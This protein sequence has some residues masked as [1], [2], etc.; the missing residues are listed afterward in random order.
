MLHYNK[1]DILPFDVTR[2]VKIDFHKCLFF[3]MEAIKRP[4]RIII[5]TTVPQNDTILHLHSTDKNDF[6]NMF[7]Y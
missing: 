3:G 4:K 1:S 6:E 5:S 2:K 7:F